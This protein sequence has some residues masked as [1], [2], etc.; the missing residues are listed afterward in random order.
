MIW[1]KVGG[2]EQGRKR[3]EA[4]IGKLLRLLEEPIQLEIA[5]SLDRSERG[6]ASVGGGGDPE[7]EA[8]ALSW[9]AGLVAGALLPGSP[10]SRESGQGLTA[11]VHAFC[12]ELRKRVG[13]LLSHCV[14]VSG[15]IE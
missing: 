6:Q 10:G 1:N 2:G 12:G 15:M 4:L 3:Q 8:L 13:S 5:S 7:A 9:R 14:A 11:G